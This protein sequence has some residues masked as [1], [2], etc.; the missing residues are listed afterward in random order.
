MQDKLD[1][2]LKKINLEKDLYTY[3]NNGSLEKIILNNAKDNCHIVIELENTLN[4]DIYLKLL[5]LFCVIIGGPCGT[6]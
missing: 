4:L 3:F 6:E 5:E 1:L 2:L